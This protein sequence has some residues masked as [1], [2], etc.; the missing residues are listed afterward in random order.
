MEALVAGAVIVHR[1]LTGLG[2]IVT[3]RIRQPIQAP[4]LA[5]SR[6]KGGYDVDDRRDGE[7]SP[8]AGY[9]DRGTLIHDCEPAPCR[10]ASRSLSQGM[11]ISTIT[12]R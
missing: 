1:E 7:R 4:L 5:A 12:G 3:V 8:G 6:D 10:Q 2:A 11:V 9:A